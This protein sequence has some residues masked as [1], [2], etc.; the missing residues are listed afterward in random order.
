M[1]K[2][3]YMYILYI[4]TYMWVALVNFLILRMSIFEHLMLDDI[5]VTL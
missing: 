3:I 2:A 1:T 4:Y 5:L